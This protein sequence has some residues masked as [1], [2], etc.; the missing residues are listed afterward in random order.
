M[1]PAGSAFNLVCCSW[2]TIPCL[3]DILNDIIDALAGMALKLWPGWSGTPPGEGGSGKWL[4]RA[5]RLCRENHP[6][7]PKGFSKSIQVQ[8]LSEIMGPAGLIVVLAVEN[9]GVDQANIFSFVKACQWVASESAARVAVLLPPEFSDL[10]EIEAISYGAVRHH[11]PDKGKAI[12][13]L[14]CVTVSPSATLLPSEALPP[15]E[16]APPFESTLSPGIWER[17]PG[18]ADEKKASIPLP[19]LGVPHPLSQGEQLMA[20]TL[21]GD[22]ELSALFEFNQKVRTLHGRHYIVDLLW[23]A[24]KVVVEIDGYTFH[25]TR[26]A[27]ASDRNRDYELMISSYLVLRIPHWEVMDDPDRALEK[28]RDILAFRRKEGLHGV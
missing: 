1:Q 5:A 7:L 28:I 16:A 21:A 8:Q 9:N 19:E 15:S 23:K 11:G 22:P 25:G 18:R 26:A 27:F 4:E 24:G 6:P 14:P 3:D 10:E 17:K 20:A 2:E 12:S 13:A